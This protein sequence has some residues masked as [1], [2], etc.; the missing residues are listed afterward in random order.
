MSPFM[1]ITSSPYLR[2]LMQVNILPKEKCLIYY[3]VRLNFLHR[4]FSWS[5]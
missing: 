4:G 1:V 2:Q 5:N 3:S